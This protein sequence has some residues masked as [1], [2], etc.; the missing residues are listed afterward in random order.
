MA[1]LGIGKKSSPKAPPVESTDPLD[2][3]DEGVSA[4]P[5]AKKKGLFGG[6]KSKGAPKASKAAAKAAPKSATG[7][8]GGTRRTSGDLDI[9]SAVLAA[10]VVALAA[11]CVL[12]AL[13]NL[14]GV[15]GTSEAGNPFA[16]VS[17]R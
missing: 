13:D 1:F 11:G 15:E 6:G 7:S 12:I 9:Y 16:V 3:S 8:K 4:A 10:A 5:P 14:A 17:S 2:G